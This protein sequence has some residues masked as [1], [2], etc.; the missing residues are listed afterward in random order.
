MSRIP[1][2]LIKVRELIALAAQREGVQRWKPKRKHQGTAARAL[3][4]L[5]LLEQSA[6]QVRNA[7]TLLRSHDL[8]P[9]PARALPVPRSQASPE[10]CP[11]CGLKMRRVVDANGSLTIEYS[12]SEWLERCERSHLGSAALCQ[13]PTSGSEKLH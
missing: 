1:K 3:A 7:R 10:L 5:K 4:L 11:R 2:R 12:C 9:D 8:K 6:R 13:L